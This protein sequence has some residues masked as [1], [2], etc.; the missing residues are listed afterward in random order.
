M[1]NSVVIYDDDVDYLLGCRM[2]TDILVCCVQ[3][4]ELR[5][6]RTVRL[7]GSI[8]FCLQMV[9]LG[10]ETLPNPSS[11]TLL[12]SSV[13]ASLSFI[14]HLSRFLQLAL[15]SLLPLPPPH[16]CVYVCVCVCVC[17]CIYVRAC[18]R[19]RRAFV[20]LCVGLC[21]CNPDYFVP[22]CFHSLY[23]IP[24]FHFFIELGSRLV[25]W[26]TGRV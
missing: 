1:Q 4:L 18:V 26:L 16:V 23:S 21:V 24:C 13:S 15:P 25:V 17:V 20:C 14:R 19:G 9:S 11:E 5:F 3:Y 2:T 7:L 6:N 12:L 10:K 22:F 8:V